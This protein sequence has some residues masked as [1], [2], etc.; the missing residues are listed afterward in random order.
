VALL[1]RAARCRRV[2]AAVAVAALV[3]ALL[4]GIAAA[5][6]PPE[7]PRFAHLGPYAA[8]VTTL[9]LGDRSVEVWYPARPSAVKGRARD[10]YFIRRWLP[11]AIEQILP[12]DA[13]PPKR[14]D[15]VRDVPVGHGGPFP[16]VVY[17]HGFA[18][19]RTVSSFLM[20]HLASWGFVVAAPDFLERGLASVL[21]QRPA[22]SQ[23]DLQTLSKTIARVRAASAEPGGVLSGAVRRGR[24]GLV[25]HSA[26][27][28]SSLELANADP[29]VATYVALAGSGSIGRPGTEPVIPPDIP[30]LY[31]FGRDDHVADATRLRAYY[32]TVPAPKELIEIGGAGH[33]NA[34]SDICTIG[35][36]G[37]GV[38]AIGRDAGLAVPDDLARLATDG[39]EPPALAP[40]VVQPVVAHYATAQLRYALGL[41]RAPIG[42]GAASARRFRGVDVEVEVERTPEPTTSE[43]TRKN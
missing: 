12:A 39:C 32:D 33:Q 6:R 2:G 22:V 42:L 5:A 21:G 19:F 15:A 8:G 29:S 18:G 11:P 28:R 23:T 40:A 27:V 25:G 38:V 43:P 7:A 13:N 1:S 37:G 4:P 26:G 24:I 20:T 31:V 17:S 9:D 3:T 30:S 10:A 14:T 16:L 35:R 34:F 36:S 41:D